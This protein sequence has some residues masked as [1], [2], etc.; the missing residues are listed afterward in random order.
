[1][2]RLLFR[3]NDVEQ[4]EA[5][6]VRELVAD[7]DTY[8]THAGRYGLSVA[9]IWLTDEAEYD[10]ARAL[11]DEYQQQRGEQQRALFEQQPYQP[12]WQRLQQRPAE[13]IA[14]LVAIACVLS[15]MLWPFRGW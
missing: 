6:A 7:F 5:D 8:E 11:I 14:V 12:W 13:H 4:E 9:A 3:L 2:A 1:M 10:A 15:I